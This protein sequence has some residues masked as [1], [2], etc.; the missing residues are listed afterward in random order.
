M[1]NDSI[2]LELRPVV[3]AE[4]KQYRGFLDELNVMLAI[5]RESNIA[6]IVWIVFF[7]FILGLEL[8]VLI[9]KWTEPESDYEVRIRQQM[10]LHIRRIEL[11]KSQ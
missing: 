10:E 7:L 8:F 6:L 5:L 1:K 11:L 2:L 3:E 4:L 9:S